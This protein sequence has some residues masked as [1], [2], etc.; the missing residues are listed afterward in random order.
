MPMNWERVFDAITEGLI[1]FDHEGQFVYAN[2]AGAAAF[3]VAPDGLAG[4]RLADFTQDESSA[5]LAGV[6][7]HTID[8]ERASEAEVFLPV[9]QRWQAV[10]SYPSESGV[11]VF[12][13]D[14]TDKKMAEDSLRVSEAK[15]AGI[16]NISADAI[17]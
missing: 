17:I 6:L 7:N 3:G 9:T 5:S 14:I 12:L 11:T 1:A 10:R 8:D 15:F 4:R 16:V 13:Q 2:R